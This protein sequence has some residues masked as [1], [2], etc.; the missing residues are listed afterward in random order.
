MPIPALDESVTS[1]WLSAVLRATG[2]LP[3]GEVSRVTP[4]A[5][6]AFNSAAL[7]LEVAYSADAPPDAPARLFLKR[8]IAAPWAIEAGAREVAFYRLVAPYRAELPMIVPCYGAEAD[9]ATGRSYVLLLDV[10]ATHQAPVT[11]DDL[12]AGQG[13][14]SQA[15]LDLV[16]DTIAA[17]HAFW[18]EHSALGTT[19]LGITPWYRDRAAWDESMKDG[20]DEWAAFIAAEGEWFPDSL[21]TLYECILAGQS[22]WWDRYLAPR[23]TTHRN[24]T[25]SHGDGYLSQFLCPREGASGPTYLID[26]QG[27]KGDFAT[28]DLVHLFAIFWTPEQRHEGD[29]ELRCLRRYHDA[30]Q[31]HGVRGYTWEQLLDDYCLRLIC[32]LQVTVWD[33]TNGSARSY[34]WPKMQCL[35]AAFRDHDAWR[36]LE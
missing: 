34:W 26:F 7:H 19:A 16:V 35:A 10:S 5:N 28:D 33:Q 27:P 18:W 30:L 11:R 13:V 23:V 9:E 29:R 2:A 15:H 4:R 1:G 21:R 25:L 8:N 14:P 24:L 31:A 32:M 36:L 6:E 22:T 17:F 12:L 20:H 3:T